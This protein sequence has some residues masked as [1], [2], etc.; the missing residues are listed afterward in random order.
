MEKED[1]ENGHVENGHATWPKKPRIGDKTDFTRWRVKDNDSCHT[2]HYLD[3]DKAAEEWSQ[4][5]AEKYF[6]NLP[7][8]SLLA[9][10]LCRKLINLEGPP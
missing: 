9:R 1:L 8:V 2:W 5:H 3:N 6:L 10:V 7:T 4:T